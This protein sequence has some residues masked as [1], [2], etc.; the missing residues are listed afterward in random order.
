MSWKPIVIASLCL[1]AIP[2]LTLPQ[3]I[4]APSITLT[5]SPWQPVAR[6]D[7]NKPFQ[8]QIINKTGTG[9]EYSSTTNEFSPRTLASGATT[10]V[11]QLP[12]PVYL[13]IN[14]LDS[15]FNLKYTVSTRNNLVTV[16]VTQLAESNPG[17]STVNIQTTG[18]IFIY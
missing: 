7:P 12:T 10:R 17:Y 2:L 4:A 13:L 3:A 5:A 14:S 16:T 9:L 8:V 1:S 11:S 6:I 18:G 15:R